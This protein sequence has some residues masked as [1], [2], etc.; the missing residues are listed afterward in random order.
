MMGLVFN[1]RLQKAAAGIGGFCLYAVRTWG[2]DPARVFFRRSSD[3][4]R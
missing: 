4:L 2:A 1:K 3:Y